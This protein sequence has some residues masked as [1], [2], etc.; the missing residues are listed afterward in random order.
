MGRS[1]G[2]MFWL[3]SF[4]SKSD[5]CLVW[6]FSTTE[7]RKL[8]W[9]EPGVSRHLQACLRKMVFSF[10]DIY[11]CVGQ[12]RQK[13]TLAWTHFSWNIFGEKVGLGEIAGGLLQVVLWIRHFFLSGTKCLF[14]QVNSS[15]KYTAEWN[16][17]YL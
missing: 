1:Y 9:I 2:K 12:F 16:F 14:T 11:E 13:I 15:R 6:C 5:N 7:K 3:V 4:T 17:I 8:L 10:W